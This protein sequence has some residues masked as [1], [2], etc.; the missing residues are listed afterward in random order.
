MKSTV[1]RILLGLGV[2]V[3]LLAGL[4]GYTM[5][6]VFGTLVPLPGPTAELAG[7]ATLIVDSY[8]S[9]YLVPTQQGRAVLID[10]GMDKDAKAIAKV[11]AEKKV[12]LEAILLTHGHP[13][14]LG[15]AATLAAPLW[16]MPE[17]AGGIAGTTQY[18]GPLP[19]TMG[20]TPTGLKVARTLRDGQILEVGV[21]QINAFLVPGHTAGS[22]AYFVDGA[23]YLGDSVALRK[24]G[25][26]HAAPSLFSDDVAQ[27]LASVRALAA[28]VKDLPV[29][30]LVFSH[31]APLAVADGA[32]AARK[33]AA[34]VP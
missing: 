16:A 15:G 19:K 14:H 28:K 13:D 7:G 32:E 29:K 5:F 34:I 17:E 33:L 20:V 3:L 1:K 10:A 4:A 2:V 27:N 12:T 24:D 22:A 8:T 18:K 6:S 9:A 25:L 21:K 26:L 11:L 30:L 31:S 23:L